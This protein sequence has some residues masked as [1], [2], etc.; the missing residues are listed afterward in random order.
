MDFN[1]FRKR[2]N[3]II[4]VC[5][6]WYIQIQTPQ[7]GFAKNYTPVATRVFPGPARELVK[8]CCR[9]QVRTLEASSP[10]F[11]GTRIY[12]PTQKRDALDIGV[13]GHGSVPDAGNLCRQ[14]ILASMN[15]I[16]HAALS[17]FLFWTDKAAST[18]RSNHSTRG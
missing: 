4:S 1:K 18:A 12:T 11:T 3:T 13:N 16:Y 5:F 10:A 9:G 15:K 2:P 7:A 6:G 17:S 14:S 8:V